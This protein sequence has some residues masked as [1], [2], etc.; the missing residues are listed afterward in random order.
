MKIGKGSCYGTFGELI[1]GVLNERPFLVTLPIESL[2]SEATF[3][4]NALDSSVKG[5]Q[6]KSKAIK[7]CE[8]LL[9]MVNIKVGGTLYISSNIETG[10]GMASS[11]ADIIAAIRAAADSFNININ[12]EVISKI[13]CKIEPSDGIM[14]DEIVA[15]DYING[16]LIERLGKMPN[17][18]LLG[19]D[20][21][22]VVDTIQF[23][24]RQKA[25]T[26]KDR[27]LFLYAYQL[28]KCGLKTNNMSFVCK[29]TTI[30]ARINQKILPKPY[31]SEFERLANRF[32]CGLVIG[33]SGT[34][35]GFLLNT[36]HQNIKN[37]IIPQL[38]EEVNFIL[39][40]NVKPFLFYEELL[41]I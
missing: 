8:I 17:F 12:G 37:K 11:S 25:Y 13:A 18:L 27:E 39:G 32:E 21:G 6:E 34:V 22:G 31:F 3:I 33:H 5:S 15:Y 41:Q 38:I 20:L 1:Q 24:K 9:K 30:S 35:L 4:P 26:K 28:L 10:K 16:H 29:A 2:K 23:N 40:K 14:Y 7:A 19:F 36:E